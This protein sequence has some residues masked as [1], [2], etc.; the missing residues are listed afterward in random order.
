[1]DGGVGQLLTA[2]DVCALLRIS[3]AT[4]YRLPYFKRRAVRV[5]RAV[6]YKLTD[7]IAFEYERQRAA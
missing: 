1:M 2:K 4:F 3:R 5:G 7:V 6:R